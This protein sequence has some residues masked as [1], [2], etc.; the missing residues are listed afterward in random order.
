MRKL[1]VNIEGTQPLI[2]HSPK[3][4]N[5]LHPLAIELKKYTSKRK[6]TAEDHQMISDLE[7]RAYV[8][9]DETVGLH[10][11]NECIAKTIE[12]GA[13]A[14]RKGSDMRKFLSVDTLMAPVDILEEQNYDKLKT[15]LKYR[16]VRTVAIKKERVCRTRPRFNTWRCAFELSYDE[17]NLD[18][19]TLVNAIEYAGKY[20]GICEMRDMGY[21]R[22][23]TVVTELN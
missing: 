11:P 17:H 9:W 6:K 10:I 23:T 8:Y 5:P 13:K 21:G 16:D 1:L 12:N 14:Y 20:V 15:D 4:A 22:F 18:L 19:E 3:A 7:W 2:M